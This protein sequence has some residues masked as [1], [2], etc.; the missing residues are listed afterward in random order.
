M[1]KLKDKGRWKYEFTCPDTGQKVWKRCT[2][3]TSEDVIKFL[4]SKNLK[5]ILTVQTIFLSIHIKLSF[6][7]TILQVRGQAF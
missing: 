3:E 6:L 1:E 7:I 4:E 2:N 5:Y